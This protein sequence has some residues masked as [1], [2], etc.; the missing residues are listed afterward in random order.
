VNTN[1][2][3]LRSSRENGRPYFSRKI[4]LSST[5]EPVDIEYGGRISGRVGQWNIGTLAIRQD[6]FAAIDASDLFVGRVSANVLNDS[7]VG[8]I[9]T[10]G[11][12]TSNNTNSVYGA[13][14]QYLNNRL[15]GGQVIEGEAWYQTS[16]TP[17]REGDDTAYGAGLR[18]PNSAGLRGGLGFKEIQENFYPALGYINRADIR[19]YT[20]DLGYTHI[21]RNTWLQSWFAGVDAQRVDG[22]GGDKQ[23]Q[24]LVYRLSEIE[25]NAR[26]RV[27]LR[28]LQNYE[29]VTEPFVLYSEPGKQYVIQPGEYSFDQSEITLTAASQREFSGSIIATIGDFY[30][31]ERTGFNT[32]FNWNQSRYF[33]LTLT[34]DWN[35][36][37]LPDGRFITRLSSLTTQTAFSSKWFWVNLLQYDN[38]SEEFGINTRLQWIPRAG[39][40]GFIVL[41]YNMQDRDKDNSFATAYSDLSVKFKYTFRF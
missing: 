3:T 5:G 10:H 31:G 25:N 15:P 17:G 37:T 8:M 2:A 9:F 12:P 22:I 18:S 13:D 36:I 28:Y 30:D 38:V 19:D 20:A 6:E 1:T 35:E 16:E 14:F 23:S 29:A 7:S 41:N 39:Q 34:Y 11:D 24:V 40:E 27:Q 21:L 26:D 4:G 33:R 32:T